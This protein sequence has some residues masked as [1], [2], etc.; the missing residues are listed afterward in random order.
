MH[1]LGGPE[2]AGALGA[3]TA[4]SKRCAG[5]MAWPSY[6]PEKLWSGL[7]RSAP[8]NLVTT[9]VSLGQQ[10]ERGLQYCTGMKCLQ[11]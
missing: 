6:S 9:T 8:A 7:V 5:G 4:V 10:T 11:V 2:W 1:G 3:H